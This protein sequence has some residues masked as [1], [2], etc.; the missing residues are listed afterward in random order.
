M[1]F[2]GDS[3]NIPAKGEL[4]A[5]QFRVLVIIPAYNEEKTIGR[6]IDEIQETVPGVDIVVVNDGSSD[7][8]AKI[9]REKGTVVLSHS[10]NLGPGAATQTGYEY[11]LEYPY[12]FV[13]QLDA[14]GQHEPR[15]I[16]DLLSV[17][18]SDSADMVIGSRFLGTQGYRPSW[19]RRV[20]M[21]ILA[22]IVSL[23]I[24][25]KITDSSSGF[26]ALRKEVVE[27]F[28]TVNY[29]SDYQDADVLILTHFA[30]FRIKEVPVVMQENLSGSSLL[31]GSKFVYYGFKM[32]L[33]IIVTLLRKKPVRERR[34]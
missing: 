24:G 23:I 14:D 18:E 32:L 20:G 10:I 28:A 16:H 6:V 4:M 15:Y 22:V 25:Q 3:V 33:S 1:T 27:F 30:G 2:C 8:T 12:D 26:R 17:L 7:N 11:A 5:S 13:I 9:V 19:I 21:K 29:P 34:E 31:S